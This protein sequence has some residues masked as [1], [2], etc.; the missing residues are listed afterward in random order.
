MSTFKRCKVVMLP[1]KRG[2]IIKKWDKLYYAG[3]DTEPVTAGSAV[4]QALYIL[5]DDIIESGDWVCAFDEFIGK[6]GSFKYS[7]TNKCKKIIATTDR[8]LKIEVD[9]PQIHQGVEWGSEKIEESLPSPSQGFVQKYTDK[10]GI[11][12]ILVEYESILSYPFEQVKVSSDDTITIKPV[13]TKWNKEEVLEEMSRALSNYKSLCNEY[14]DGT[15][16]KID[17]EQLEYLLDNPNVNY[18]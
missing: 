14:P 11:D 6:F 18:L 13:K 17:D 4:N 3:N 12:N 5:S 9:R 16:A 1:V 7:Y 2:N 8:S 10:G 15:V